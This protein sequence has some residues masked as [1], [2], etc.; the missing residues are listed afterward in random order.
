M[1]SS[2][3]VCGKA[4]GSGMVVKTVCDGACCFRTGVHD[5]CF[6][7]RERTGIRMLV[8][9]RGALVETL[10]G[11]IQPKVWKRFKAELWQS[12]HLA[13]QRAVCICVCGGTWAPTERVR[14][15]MATLSENVPPESNK[16]N[17]AFKRLEFERLELE[18]ERARRREARA[19]LELAKA[20]AQEEKREKDLAKV[21]ARAARAAR[22]STRPGAAAA[23]AARVTSASPPRPSAAVEPSS[24]TEIA[25]PTG[26]MSPSYRLLERALE[27]GVEQVPLVK[28]PSANVRV[29]VSDTAVLKR[30]PVSRRLV[31][32]VV[33]TAPTAPPPP[34]SLITAAPP[35]RVTPSV[36]ALRPRPCPP[37][38]VI[39]LSPF[40]ELSLLTVP[41][42]LR[43]IRE[44]AFECGCACEFV[45]VAE[46]EQGT[47]REQKHGKR[48]PCLELRPRHWSM[49][50]E[51]LLKCAP[52]DD[53]EEDNEKGK[54]QDDE[55]EDQEDGTEN[56]VRFSWDALKRLEQAEGSILWLLRHEHCGSHRAWREHLHCRQVLLHEFHLRPSPVEL[57]PEIRPALASL[58]QGQVLSELERAMD[59]QGETVFAPGLSPAHVRVLLHAPRACCCSPDS[60]SATGICASRIC[61]IHVL[62]GQSASAD[63]VAECVAAN[64]RARLF[65]DRPYTAQRRRV[66][67]SSADA[68]MAAIVPARKASSTMPPPPLPPPLLPSELTDDHA[69]LCLICLEMPI[70]RIFV[71]CGHVSACGACA[72]AWLATE[73]TCPLCHDEATDALEAL[74]A[75]TC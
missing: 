63:F 74:H 39:T 44:E 54:E 50:L 51:T 67:D 17:R 34:V 6:A 7:R 66:S 70:S 49:A 3:N 52:C 4:L 29:G 41:S 32:P 37:P 18:E 38:L 12:E 64:V 61:T 15:G 21:A 2:C 58:S 62:I 30:L 22:L 71:P 13:T 72:D 59:E 9:N 20:T 25:S 31:S 68:E 16:E 65:E 53:E 1:S 27:H 19:K 47:Q 40:E 45:G 26:P 8:S 46:S 33:L 35:M 55:E 43:A 48:A 23:A 56:E 28:L 10:A 57:A 36:V 75:S 5:E 24:P 69:G 60:T 11:C 73:R 42:L 14:M